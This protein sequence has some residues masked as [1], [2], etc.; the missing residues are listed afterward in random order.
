MLL[1][2][3]GAQRRVDRAPYSGAHGRA[4][5]Q[6]AH[7]RAAYLLS[8]HRERRPHSDRRVPDPVETENRQQAPERRGRL[9][10]L[11]LRGPTSAVAGAS[12]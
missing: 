6:V 5:S 12:G 9:T 11:T 10:Q 3:L 7:F 1:I 4:G 8:P 2:R